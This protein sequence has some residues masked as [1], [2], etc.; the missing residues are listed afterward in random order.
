M[1]THVEL[2]P[3]AIEQV[4]VAGDSDIDA[5]S[6]TPADEGVARGYDDDS[7]ILL[8]ES[9]KNKVT[10]PA[11]W[12]AWYCG[13][14]IVATIAEG[15]GK[16]GIKELGDTRQMIKMPPWKLLK[17]WFADPHCMTGIK[18]AFTLKK[19]HPA[20]N[21][22]SH[23]RDLL[24]DEAVVGILA[25]ARADSIHELAQAVEADWPWMK[26]FIDRGLF[27]RTIGQWML[28]VSALL[29]AGEKVL[30]SSPDSARIDMC[31]LCTLQKIPYTI[32][33]VMMLTTPRCYEDTYY[34]FEEGHLPKGTAPDK[35][36]DFLREDVFERSADELAAYESIDGPR[37]HAWAREQLDD[38]D[39]ALLK[40]R[41]GSTYLND[42]GSKLIT[43]MIGP[44]WNR[45]IEALKSYADTVEIPLPAT[46]TRSLGDRKLALL[47]EPSSEAIQLLTGVLNSSGLNDEPHGF[48]E[49]AKKRMA[50]VH[51]V[52]DQIQKLG[53]SLT[54][55][56]ML[57]LA[58]LAEQGRQE[59]VASKAW[60]AEEI[61]TYEAE[62]K[63]WETF[64]SEW[65]Q[66]AEPPPGAKKAKA[67]A[68][69]AAPVRSVP[70][71]L[72]NTAQTAQLAELRKELERAEER[73][74]RG[75][76]EL[77]EARAEVY[78]LKQAMEYRPASPAQDVELQLD[79][80]LVRRVA[81]RKGMTPADVLA[82]LQAV[83]DDRVEVLE[84][85]WKSAREAANFVYPEKMLE[86]LDL[87][88]NPYYESLAAGNPDSVAKDVLGNHYSAKESKTTTQNQRLR[89]LREF[90]YCGKK[91]LF[92]R[93][94]RVGSGVGARDC[95]RIY[96]EI[97][98]SK[99]V[100]AYAGE[101]LEVAT[102]N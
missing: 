29:R 17:T 21:S 92:E 90:D 99:V 96:F 48:K 7:I 62:A 38:I 100:I 16:S 69:A 43:Q 86:L 66:L 25:I 53:T 93:H 47:R 54:A 33:G 61:Q 11:A 64:F 31:V 26:P 39:Q 46:L 49:R 102:T 73:A 85:A 19:F 8:P 101:H 70:M 42:V 83:S 37:T 36:W 97:I 3:E 35:V 1:N 63:I 4:A 23:T 15:I 76:H 45:L 32:R 51:E 88:V 80:D 2:N 60:F 82:Y 58:E 10:G 34:T 75:D 52:Q 65:Q 5:T 91:I 89:A 50:R 12:A 40:C 18:R 30:S 77:S 28:L 44:T 56:G 78:R 14:K 6:A 24:G 27:N 67:K 95:M 84:S 98:G 41:P 13:Q 72:E 59:I 68:E 22:A 57:K 71:A 9:F 74:Q 20:T 81:T 94:L 87:L 55:G 79:V